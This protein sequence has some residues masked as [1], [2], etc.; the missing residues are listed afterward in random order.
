MF[1]LFIGNWYGKETTLENKK[2]NPQN[3]L[4]Q[5]QKK[6]IINALKYMQKICNSCMPLFYVLQSVFPCEIR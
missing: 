4:Q 5:G 2:L 1:V 3:L 6:D